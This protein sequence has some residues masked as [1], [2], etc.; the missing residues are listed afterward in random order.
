MKFIDTHSHLYSEQFDNDRTT[1]INEAIALGVDTIL[2]PNISSKYTN[3]LLKLCNQFPENCFPMMGLHPC[4][5]SEE[6]FDSEMQHVEIELTKN[7]YIAV[8]EIG[9]DL[10][11]DKTKLEVQKRAFIYQIKLAKQYQIPIAIHVRDAFDEAIEIVES[12]N[13]NTLRGVFHCFTGSIVQAKRVIDLKDFYLG[14]GGVI[15]FKNSGLDQTIKEISLKNLILETDSPYLAPV[16]FRGKRNE[17]KYLTKIAEKIAEIKNM[18][19]KEI[20][21]ITTTNAKKLFHI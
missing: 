14:I 20:A 1:A 18:T 17:S 12:L 7:K 2:L 6:N 9:L 10:Y 21:E 11:W 15:T 3:N 4:D 13:D 5:V 19:I 8:G 16:P